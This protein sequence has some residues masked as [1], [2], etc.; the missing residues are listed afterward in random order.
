ME[1]GKIEE[2]FKIP[3]AYTVYSFFL[4]FFEFLICSINEENRNSLLIPFSHA[5]HN[6][7]VFSSRFENK[8]GI[9]LNIRVHHGH[10]IFLNFLFLHS[11]RMNRFH[12]MLSY[13]CCEGDGSHVHGE[14]TVSDERNS[15]SGVVAVYVFKRGSNKIVHIRN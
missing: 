3:G 10:E 15:G 7:F 6:D 8:R 5:A 11:L 14:L 12:L 9:V 2:L 1:F 13:S 4:N